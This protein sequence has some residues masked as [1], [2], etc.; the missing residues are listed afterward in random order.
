[1]LVQNC[2]ILDC[3]KAI[4]ERLKKVIFQSSSSHFVGDENAILRQISG[5][6]QE[7][8]KDAYGDFGCKIHTLASNLLDLDHPEIKSGQFVSTFVE[9]QSQK[10]FIQFLKLSELSKKHELVDLTSEISKCI[11]KNIMPDIKSRID[12]LKNQLQF[13][14]LFK[15]KEDRNSFRQMKQMRSIEFASSLNKHIGVWETVHDLEAYARFGNFFK[16]QIAVIKQRAEIYNK[17]RMQSMY[18]DMIVSIKDFESTSEEQYFGF[19]RVPLTVLSIILAKMHGGIHDEAL[20]CIN[21]P[22]KIFKGHRF[23]ESSSYYFNELG[24]GV[25]KRELD[26]RYSP[27]TYPSHCLPIS[28]D[29]QK[30]IDHLECFPEAN[31][32]PIFDHFVVVVPSVDLKISQ[33]N[34]KFYIINSIGNREYFNSIHEARMELDTMLI[35]EGRIVPALVGEKDGKCYFISFF[36]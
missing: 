36:I 8:C 10:R 26:Y 6:S 4:Q 12:A 35:K 34:G 27:M 5:M 30:I 24:V 18:Q 19:Q 22:S 20:N 21:I 25:V 3:A 1:M 32:K 33:E 29:T 16:D 28:L 13:L 15:N 14:R 31:F 9:E 2:D 23:D 17:L 11:T 7:V